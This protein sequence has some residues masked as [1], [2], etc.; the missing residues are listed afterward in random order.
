MP[1]VGT[2]SIV[3]F[4]KEMV[5][6]KWAVPGLFEY[7]TTECKQQPV[8][9]DQQLMGLGI[10]EVTSPHIREQAKLPHLLMSKDFQR[11]GTEVKQSV[12]QS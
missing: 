3:Q 7:T 8:L 6:G 11:H 10:V 9:S 5:A 4:W 2:D 1:R 12:G